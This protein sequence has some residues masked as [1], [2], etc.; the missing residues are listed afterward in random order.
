MLV[1]FKEETTQEVTTH[2]KIK[3]ENSF[4]DIEIQ[5]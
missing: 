1:T 3:E 4:K 2:I 5:F